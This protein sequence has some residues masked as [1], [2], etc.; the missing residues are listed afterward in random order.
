MMFL[1]FNVY[2]IKSIKMKTIK[3]YFYV[4]LFLMPFTVSAQDLT[5]VV[6]DIRKANTENEYVQA[7]NQLERL[8]M[9]NP[10]EWL[11]HY[12]LA[13]TD[14]QLSFRASSKEEKMKYIN[15]AQTYLK[16]LSDMLEADVSEVYTLKGFRLYALIA[17]DP[18]S[19][20][21]RYFGE[22]TLSYEKALGVNSN[23]PRA[24]ML[25]ALFKNDMAKFM[26][27]SYEN[28]N[29]DM[30]KAAT[31]FAGESAMA[32]TPSWGKEWLDRLFINK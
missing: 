5:R 2:A 4:I 12:Y 9:V 13:Y 15:D 25:L 6:E 22:I 10:K 24:I 17:S 30:E 26:N 16:K 20:G 27:K 3:C 32:L 29:Q 23:N 31:L 18:Q 21:P 7:R 19:N 8:C 14:V 1:I 11:A 28:F